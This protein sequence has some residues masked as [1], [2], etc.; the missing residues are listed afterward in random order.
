MRNGTVGDRTK[1]VTQHP[2]FDLELHD[3]EGSFCARHYRLLGWPIPL[4]LLS[5]AD[6]NNPI[7]A[8]LISFFLSPLFPSYP[9]RS[10][11]L[12]SFTVS[13]L[14]YPRSHRFHRAAQRTYQGLDLQPK[15]V[16][17][18]PLLCTIISGQLSSLSQL[19]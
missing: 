10:L 16:V 5:F 14:V 12:D 4:Q 18:Q 3:S 8:N 19:F 11:Q 2:S 7:R 13:P 9:A 15:E 6:G 1:R 17:H